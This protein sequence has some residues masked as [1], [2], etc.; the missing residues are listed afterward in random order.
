MTDPL[1]SPQACGGRDFVAVK[2]KRGGIGQIGRL[3]GGPPSLNQGLVNCVKGAAPLRGMMGFSSFERK[4][5]LFFPT[6]RRERGQHRQGRRE[7]GVTTGLLTCRERQGGSSMYG[8]RA[9]WE[10]R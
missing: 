10:S 5:L 1:L 7:G 2:G 8:R 9:G 6:F 4:A 3:S